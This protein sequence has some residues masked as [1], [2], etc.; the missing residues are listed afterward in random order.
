MSFESKTVAAKKNPYFNISGSL[1]IFII[2]MAT[3]IP[4]FYCVTKTNKKGI[5][6]ETGSLLYC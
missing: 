6:N 3:G 4:F 5:A 2:T 1:E